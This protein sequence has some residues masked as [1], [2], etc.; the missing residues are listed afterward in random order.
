MPH[1]LFDWFVD[2]S[3]RNMRRRFVPQFWEA[4][5]D[6]EDEEGVPFG[7]QSLPDPFERSCLLLLHEAVK[8]LHQVKRKGC[9]ILLHAVHGLSFHSSSSPVRIY[10]IE[11]LIIF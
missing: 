4:F 1:L 7:R 6:E 5:P 10:P 8:K 11:A 9:D 2:S 3:K